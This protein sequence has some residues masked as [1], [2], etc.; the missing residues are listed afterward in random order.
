MNFTE[1]QNLL[2]F[3][4]DTSCQYYN[5]DAQSLTNCLALGN[6]SNINPYNDIKACT[7]ELKSKSNLEYC[8]SYEFDDIL[9][10][11]GLYSALME[12]N[13][14]CDRQIIA[15][16]LSSMIFVAFVIGDGISGMLSDKFGR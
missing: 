10:N 5:I 6:S 7:Q 15:T 14:L 16:I 12:Y 9:V 8:S 4:D 11:N 13:L 3:P 2:S 1:K